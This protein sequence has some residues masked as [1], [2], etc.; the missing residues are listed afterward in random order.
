MLSKFDNSSLSADNWIGLIQ[1]AVLYDNVVADEDDVSKQEDDF[2]LGQQEEEETST[3]GS[4]IDKGDEE[5]VLTSSGRHHWMIGNGLGFD[6]Q[7]TL[8]GIGVV[9]QD[10]HLHHQLDGGEVSSPQEDTR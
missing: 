2:L 10:P 6:H 9:G 3:I 1:A 4:E 7:C 5:A 8:Q